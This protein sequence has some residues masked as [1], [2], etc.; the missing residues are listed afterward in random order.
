MLD[1]LAQPILT[2]TPVELVLRSR[3]RRKRVV[4]PLVDTEQVA[5]VV[6]PVLSVT[7]ERRPPLKPF[8]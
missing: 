7:K 8:A 1:H 5:P 2:V 3:V 4:Q 6:A